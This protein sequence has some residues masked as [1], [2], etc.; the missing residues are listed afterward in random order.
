MAETV[1]V[2]F[3]RGRG[4]GLT[5]RRNHDSLTDIRNVVVDRMAPRDE[6]LKSFVGQVKN[7]YLFK[8]GNTVVRVNF[9]GEKD[10]S[11]L[12]ADIFSG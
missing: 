7:P 10:L 12:L 11:F 1:G 4:V 2:A 5:E 3:R 9:C 8:V 6:R